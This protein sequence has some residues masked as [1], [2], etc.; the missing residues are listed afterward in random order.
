[1]NTKSP[2]P[3][4]LG[5]WTTLSNTDADKNLIALSS[6]YVFPWFSAD[7]VLSSGELRIDPLMLADFLAKCTTRIVPTTEVIVHASLA[8]WRSVATAVRAAYSHR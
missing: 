7:Y 2:W 6:K 3:A 1:M 8:A 4:A 5:D